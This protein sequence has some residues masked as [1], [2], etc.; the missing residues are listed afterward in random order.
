MKMKIKNF[1]R[2]HEVIVI[3]VSDIPEQTLFYRNILEACSIRV[4]EKNKV[5]S[6]CDLAHLDVAIEFKDCMEE[7]KAN[8]HSQKRCKTRSSNAKYLDYVEEYIKAC[9]NQDQKAINPE[10]YIGARVAKYFFDNNLDLFFGSVTKYDRERGYW[11]IQYDDGD[12]EEFDYVQLIDGTNLR[13][14]NASKEVVC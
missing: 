12:E 8:R 5:T 1:L 3:I 9:K 2:R 13:D 4:I 7:I 14:Q 11:W 10:G 6:I